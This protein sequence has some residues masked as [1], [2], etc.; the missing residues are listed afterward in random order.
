MLIHGGEPPFI[1]EPEPRWGGVVAKLNAFT[2][3][4][5]ESTGSYNEKT[6]ALMQDFTT[7]LNKF[8]LDVVVPIDAHFNAQGAVHGEDKDT[9]GLGQKD[10]FR[11]ATLEEMRNLVAVDAFVTPEGAKAAFDNFV[12][13][14]GGSIDGLQT[15]DGLRAGAFYYPDAYPMVKP[16]AVEP[17]RYFGKEETVQPSPTKEKWTCRVSGA[18]TSTQHWIQYSE[19]QKFCYGNSLIELQ[20]TGADT[21]HYGLNCSACGRDG[22]GSADQASCDALTARHFI[23]TPEYI[24]P[25]PPDPVPESWTCSRTGY[26]TSSFY[27]PSGGRSK[28]PW[29]MERYTYN[30]IRCKVCGQVFRNDYGLSGLVSVTA[31][32][33]TYT[34][35]YNPP[36]P[37]P[38][39]VP[40]LNV[41]DAAAVLINEDRMLI[42]PLSDDTRHKRHVLFASGPIRKKGNPGFQ[43]IPNLETRYLGR[44]WNS[45]GGLTLN[46]KTALFRPLADKKIYEYKNSLAMSGSNLTVQL[47]RGYADY[48]Y[49]GLAVTAA[50]SN[51]NLILYHKFFHV[52][53]LETDPTLVETVTSSYTALFT[54]IGKV[55]AAAPANGSHT[56]KLL[57]FVTLQPNQTLELDEDMD[58]I[59]TSLFWK[60]QDVELYLHVV[61]PVLVK[62]AGRQVRCYL[63]FVESIKPGKLVAG[64]A[65]TFTLLGAYVKD[66]VDA[67]FKAQPGA[68]WIREND[69]YELNNP[70]M[71]PG[72]VTPDGELIKAASNV[73]AIRVKRGNIT[74]SDPAVWATNPK[75]SV[76]TNKVIN[77]IYPPSRYSPLGNMPERIIPLP[78]EGSTGTKMLAYSVDSSKGKY[79]WVGLD[80]G[81]LT[82]VINEASSVFGL[83]QAVETPNAQM[84]LMPASLTVRGAVANKSVELGGLA[85]TSRNNYNGYQTIITE[86]GSVSGSNTV[87]LDADALNILRNLGPA[88]VSRSVKA[89]PKVN[90]F[91]MSPEV[92]VFAFNGTLALVLITDGVCYGEAA[93]VN[94]TVS[95][96]VFKPVVTPALALKPVTTGAQ[97]PTGDVR[98]S[99]TGDNVW[100]RFSDCFMSQLNSTTW[101]FVVSRPFGDLFGDLAFSSTAPSL[102]ATLTPLAPNVAKM[103]KGNYQFDLVDEL[104]PPVLIPGKGLYRPN[105]A[106]KRYNNTLTGIGVGGSFDPYVPNGAGWVQLPAGS[107]VM[108]GGKAM[109]LKQA[110]SVKVPTSGTAY[111][112]LVRTGDE[113]SVVSSTTRREASNDEV[114]FGVSVNGIL[115][116]NHS[117]LVMADKV[118]TPARQGSA[119]PAID[120]NGA[121]GVN[122]FFTVRDKI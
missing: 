65:A 88:V 96:G 93:F 26:T 94:Y 58:G 37:V 43:E 32:H 98:S 120:D 99:I 56:Y 102:T 71:F 3:A 86:G 44:T 2:F 118:I 82:P 79:R 23:Y 70:V 50:V 28:V 6:K 27:Y 53:N 100:L 9:I 41:S 114:M 22:A 14:T 87:T 107:R 59:V 105:P 35:A 111:C 18:S 74:F 30:F 62:S 19:N 97:S 89:N 60:V 78:T 52:A 1:E 11:T 12:P 40:I 92:S 81:T 29:F 66:V 20:I 45:L 36:S 101:A 16:T 77:E 4:L 54:Q 42:S 8:I 80:W 67:D 57:D 64:G 110:Y 46:G 17:V 68:Q 95:N 51:T 104:L 24:P 15:N 49:K 85:F 115:E 48:I 55:P 63:E 83:T 39:P 103:Y 69:P 116:I 38:T 76:P 34:P 72:V 25:P 47:F 106:N 91:T 31:A 33:C 109:T 5:Q 90:E 108:L 117:Y 112:Y 121:T 122:K 7:N 10:N 13:G 75:E 21:E 84:G 119:I 61:I 113:L 73:N